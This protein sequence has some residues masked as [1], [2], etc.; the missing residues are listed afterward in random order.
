MKIK[1]IQVGQISVP[2]KKP[3]KT[4]LRTVDRI[5]DVVV[6]IITDTGHIGYGEA[7]PTAVITGDTKGSIKCAIEDFIA[8]QIIGLEIENIEEIMNRIDRSLIKNTSAKAAVDIAIYDLFG[9]LHKSPL[10]KLLGGYKKEIISDLTISVN[11]PEEMAQD[12]IEAVRRGYKTLK[13]KVGLD[14]QMDI[15]R[16][17]A[18]RDTVGYNVD[19]RLDANQGWKPKEAV[20][21]LRKMEDKG[22]NI[23][24]VEQPVSANDLEGLKYVTQNV[25]TPILAD[26]SVFSPFDAVKII[27]NRAADLINIKLMKTG[28]IHN[29]LKICSVAEIY[30]VECMIGCMLE[31]K[32]SVSAAVHLA[33]S[34][35]IITKIDLDGPGLCKEDPVDGGPQ[36]QD[37]KITL[38]DEWGLGFKNIGNL[39]F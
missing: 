17:Q 38:N 6:K 4:A 14:S 24:L 36:F 25:N 22:F 15:K 28:G 16:I 34:K 8:P 7:A 10:Y 29:A 23:E 27:Q 1:E 20:M 11:D 19:L 3:F 12:S 31:S 21:L 5:E 26:E 13:I 35:S 33:A 32:L 2:L 37:Y 9:Q 30:G 18:I 39:S